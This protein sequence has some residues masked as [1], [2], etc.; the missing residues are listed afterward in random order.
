[1]AVK[2]TLRGVSIFPSPEAMKK[3]SETRFIQWYLPFTRSSIPAVGILKQTKKPIDRMR[4]IEN[5]TLF[6]FGIFWLIYIFFASFRFVSSCFFRSLPFRFA[7]CL[8]ASGRFVSFVSFRSVSCRSLPFAL[9]R[10][11]FI[12]IFF[13]FISS[14]AAIFNLKQSSFSFWSWW[15]LSRYFEATFSI[16]LTWYSLLVAWCNKGCFLG[17]ETEFYHRSLEG[18]GSQ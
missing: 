13:V 4:K 5:L 2:R 6:V 8:T 9:Y 16:N 17:N 11:F 10:F 14:N 7:S 3:L 15:V 1:M 12:N 18:S